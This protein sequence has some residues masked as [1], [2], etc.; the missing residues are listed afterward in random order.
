[1][2]Q[3]AH[4][5]L[6]AAPHIEDE[7]S[8]MNLDGIVQRFRPAYPPRGE[9]QPGWKWV[10]DLLA[11]SGDATRYASAREAFKALSPKVPELA[12]F[13]WD[14]KAPVAQLKRGINPLPT[15]ADG[16]PPGY[17]E[18]GAPRVRGI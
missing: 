18:F 4:V 8:F 2:A 17:R 15:G 5:V 11:E 3:A 14:A 1:V 7:G 6:P 16:R 12:S 13:E 10:S 9:A